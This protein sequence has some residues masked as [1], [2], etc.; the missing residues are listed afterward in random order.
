[1]LPVLLACR[2]V[3]VS[4]FGKSYKGKVSCMQAYREMRLAETVKT[5]R[6][7]IERRDRHT[8]LLYR[9]ERKKALYKCVQ[10]LLTCLYLGSH[11]LGLRL[12][13]RHAIPTQ[14]GLTTIGEA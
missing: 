7:L 14:N 5:V 11:T 3:L 6:S 12:H 1:M 2:L 10:K 9:S 13:S 8:R 4:I